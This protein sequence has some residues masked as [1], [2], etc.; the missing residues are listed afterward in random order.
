VSTRPDGDGAPAGYSP[1]P[2]ATPPAFP[3]AVVVMGVSGSGKSTVGEALAR[4][5]GARFI[6]ADDFHPPANID[7]MRRGVPLDDADR[8]PWL[9]RLN[10]LLRQAVAL[11]E[12][13]VLACSALRQRYRDTLGEA[14]PGLRVVH[15][16]GSSALIAERLAAR[17]HRYMPASLLQSQFDAL[18]A[19]ANAIVIDVT[20]SVDEIADA[21]AAALVSTERGSA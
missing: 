20:G 17:R 11:D 19:P 18:E 10:A 2:G 13:V 8:A 21:A 15:L 5:F 6:D 7:K 3:R 16:S 9:A 1:E 12:P 4:R 14:L